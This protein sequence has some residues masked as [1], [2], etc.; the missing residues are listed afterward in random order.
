M[1]FQRHAALYLELVDL[2]L[3]SQVSCTSYIHHLQ[4]STCASLCVHLQGA[5]VQW[6]LKMYASNFEPWRFVLTLRCACRQ[7]GY[8]RHGVADIE[9]LRCQPSSCSCHSAIP[10]F[11]SLTASSTLRQGPCHT[12][13]SRLAVVDII[14]RWA[15][16]SE[17]PYS[18]QCLRATG[19]SCRCNSSALES[20]AGWPSS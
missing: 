1:D 20:I 18:M 6:L 9:G 17:S 3:R 11:P 5:G 15:H 14:C 2:H 16:T 12:N 13:R 4:P 19:S 10:N 8:S 7:A